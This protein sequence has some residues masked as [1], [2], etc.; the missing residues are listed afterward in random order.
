MK[1]MTMVKSPEEA[2]PPPQALMD[3]VAKLG[4]DAAKAGVLVEMGGL[5]PSAKG[6]RVRVSR[7]KLA[8]IDGPFTE[9]KEVVGGYAVY[10]VKS[11]ADAVEWARRLMELHLQHW[12]GWEGETELR[13]LF[14][15]ADFQPGPR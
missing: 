7:G 2:G 13:Q 3:A 12:P 11:K 1:F 10:S 8:V 5:A 15:P 6:A 4:E 9:T 14:D